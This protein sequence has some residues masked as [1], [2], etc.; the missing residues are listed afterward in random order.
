MNELAAANIVDNIIL[1]IVFDFMF[2]KF[3]TN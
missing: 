3:I 1:S 2:S